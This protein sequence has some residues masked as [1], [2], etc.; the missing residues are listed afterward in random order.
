MEITKGDTIRKFY[1][2]L[3]SSETFRLKR[4]LKTHKDIPALQEG[5]Y[6]VS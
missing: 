3:S 5:T 4:Y 1:T 2:E 6:V